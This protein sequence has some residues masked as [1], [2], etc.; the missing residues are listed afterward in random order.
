MN[1]LQLKY[2]VAIYERRNL[3]H[4]A[5]ELNVAQ[6]ALSH[7]VK[8]LE[9]DLGVKLFHRRPRGVEPT[10]AGGRLYEHARQILKNIDAAERDLSLLS[11]DASG[12]I[13]IG[14]TYTAV[15]AISLPLLR[16][17]RDDYPQIHL[18]VVEGIS[19]VIFEGLLSSSIDLGLLYNPP[20]DARIHTDPVLEEHVLCVGRSDLIGDCDEPITFA[21]IGKLP[22]LTVHQG[23]ASRALMNSHAMRAAIKN[24]AQ[25]EID[26]LNAMTKALVAGLG[27]TILPKVS[28]RGALADGK[29]HARRI[30]DAPSMRRL[31]IAEPAAKAATNLNTEMRNLVLAIVNEE[32]AS[33]RWQAVAYPGAR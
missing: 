29:L 27:C 22:L 18:S 2:F 28:V 10:R 33:G 13:V 9:G 21:E 15:E 24:K 6:S 17:V 4:A 25:F 30:A 5:S 1:L 20:V 11:E 23:Y 19:G 12:R 8:R 14:L 31:Y 16:R 26:S 3:S 32:V 7:H